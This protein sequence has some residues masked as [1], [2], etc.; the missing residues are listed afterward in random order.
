MDDIEKG[1][2]KRFDDYRQPVGSQDAPDLAKRLVHVPWE[3]REMVQTSL[4]DHT[5]TTRVFKWQPATITNVAFRRPRVPGDE[6]LGEIHAFHI[7][8]SNSRQRMQP[9]TPTAE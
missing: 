3:P 6:S 5:I 8:K 2:W 1:G 9:I 7:S 4:D